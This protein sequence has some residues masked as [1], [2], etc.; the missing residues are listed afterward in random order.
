MAYSRK[1]SMDS[2]CCSCKPRRVRPRRRAP[3][4]QFREASL[5]AQLPPGR[6]AVVPSAWEA[7]AETD[8]TLSAA[9]FTEGAAPRLSPLSWA[10]AERLA[11]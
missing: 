5:R 4:G 8:F 1:I 9:A 6:Y 3:H 11:L 10:A 2:P 7:G